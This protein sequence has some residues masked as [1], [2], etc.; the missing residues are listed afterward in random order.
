MAGCEI[1]NGKPVGAVGVEKSLQFSTDGVLTLTY[2]GAL[3][4]PTGT[5]NTF[6]ISLVCDQDNSNRLRLLREEMSSSSQVTHDV[7]FELKTA[8]ACPV[9]P[10]DCQLTDSHGKEYDLSDLSRDDSPWVAIDTSAQAKTRTFYI[11]VCRPLPRVLGCPGGALGTCAIIDGKG[12]N[13]GYVQ[14]NPQAAAD[15]SISIVYGNGDKCENS[16]YSTRIIFQCDDS[17]GSPMFTE[18]NGCEYVFTWRTSEACPVHRVQGDNCKVRDPRSS[19]VFD[20]TSLSGKDYTVKSG[21]YEYHFAVCGALNEKICTHKDTGNETVS[22][23]QVEGSTHRIAGLTTQTLTYDDGLIMINYTHGQT[24]HKIYERATAIL[25][26]CDHSQGTGEPQFIK[27]TPDCTYLFEWNTALACLPFKTTSCSFKDDKGNSYDLSPLSMPRSNWAVD[28]QTGNQEQRYYINVCKSLVPQSGSWRCPSTSA[29]CLKS[30]DQYFSLGEA[31]STPH[32]ERGVLV[33]KYTHGDKCPDKQRNRTTIIRF[34]CDEDKVDSSPTLITA[35]E[36]CIYTFMWFT[37]TA[38]PLKSSEHGD[39]RVANPL[40]GHLFDLNGLRRP[41]GYTVYDSVNRRKMFRLNVC[42]EVA[43]AGCEKG[44]GVCIKDSL[45]ALNGGSFSQTLSYRDQV[46]QLTYEGGD[47][48]AANPTLRHKS[49]FSFVC[50]SQGA[51][52]GGPVLV[53]TDEEK[54]IH[55]FSWHTPLVCEQQVKCSVSNGTSLIDLTPL[56]HKTGFYT[57]TDEDLSKDLSPDFYINICQPLNPIPGVACPPGTSVCMDPDN[58]PPID[59]GRITFP[60]QIN[61]AIN[62]VYISFNS[63]TP[64]PT[65]SSQNYSSLLVFSC[66]AGT[67]LGSPRMIRKSNCLYVF[68]WATPVVC[69]DAVTTKDCTLKDAQLQFTFNLSPLSG[70]IQRVVSSGSSHYSINVCGEVTDP[71][72]KG[73]AVCLVSSSSTASY[74]NSKAMTMDYQHEDEAVTMHYGSGDT[75]LPV[76][77][78]GNVCFFPFNFLGKSFSECTTEGRTDGKLWCATTGDYDKD[79]QWGFCSEVKGKRRSTVLFTCDRQAGRGPPAAE[80]DAGLRRHLPVAHRRRVPA[81]QDGVQAGAPAPDVRPAHALL[82][83]LPLEVQPRRRLVLPEP[84]PGDSRGPDRLPRGRHRL[85]AQTRRPHAGP[86]PGAHPDHGLHRREDHGELHQRGR[87]LR[88][89]PPGQNRHSADVRENG[90][91]PQASAGGR[92][93]LRVLAGVGDAGGLRCDA[94]GG[95]DGERHHPSARHGGQLQPRSPLLQVPPGL[96]GHPVQRGPVHIR[97]PALR[98]HQQLLVLLPG[99][100]HLPGEDQRRLPAE[101][102]GSAEQRQVLHQRRKFG[103]PHPF[104]VKVRAGPEE[105]GLL[106]HSVPLQPVGRRGHPR[107]PPGDGRLP[108]PLRL[109]HLQRV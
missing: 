10:V 89:E 99:G 44:A 63:T 109:A 52:G 86:G 20:M 13:L 35:I 17:P 91:E 72:C 55:F 73:S 3:D 62:E 12:V 53:D 108:V 47:A 40:T 90:G 2:K 36:D 106:H 82:A 28:S 96:G 83:H 34:K 93:G 101:D 15:G 69:P 103:R 6:I 37:A 68:E 4:T 88:A 107:I 67:E 105:D 23:C 94:A 1:E 61:E 46:V 48:C 26:T 49:V 8:L 32:L 43:N 59:I 87:G 58:G 56:I 74:G 60:P 41:E 24:C 97:H 25:F 33:L 50:A 80:R 9:A 65:D 102:R 92:A 7:F 5:R 98:H 77:T 84:V 64:C 29:S 14:S 39:C 66:Q 78:E 38:C 22:S 104:R 100:Q 51:A 18:K 31:E 57:A 81:P 76:T 95:G 71:G 70:I 75:C 30:G 27:E 16:R 42:G 45:T 85:P 79:M 11:N 54:C 21:E 19:Y